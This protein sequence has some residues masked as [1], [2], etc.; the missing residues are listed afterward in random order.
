MRR[1]VPIRVRLRPALVDGQKTTTTEVQLFES[2]RDALAK[3][4]T[5]IGYDTEGK[6]TAGFGQKTGLSTF[7]RKC[8]FAAAYDYVEPGSDPADGV[9]TAATAGGCG[10]GEWIRIVALAAIE[11]SDLP[12]QIEHARAALEGGKLDA[13]PADETPAKRKRASKKK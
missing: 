4:A 2:E 3:A 7:L 13:A 11:A 9:E 6:A 12:R 1:T 8:A 10:V 5:K